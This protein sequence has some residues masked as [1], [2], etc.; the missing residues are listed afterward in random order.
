MRWLGPRFKHGRW[1]KE[2]G[3]DPCRGATRPPPSPP[4]PEGLSYRTLAHSLDLIPSTS[5]SEMDSS[6][7]LPLN[8]RA[9][10]EEYALD[11]YENVLFSLARFHEITGR[12]PAKMTVVGY[13]MKRKRWVM[14]IGLCLMAGWLISCRFEQ[15]HRHV[16]RFPADRFEYIGIDDEGDTSEHY[17]GEVSPI[18]PWSHSPLAI[19]F[20]YGISST[21]DNLTA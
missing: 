2:A 14:G 15:L 18:T 5:L 6:A 10:T 21:A 19:R 20:T 3:A 12:W 9:V 7:P 4:L 11:S 13:G 8:L 1:S 17:A 16:I